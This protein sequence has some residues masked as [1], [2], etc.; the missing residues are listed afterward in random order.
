MIIL[1]SQD[2]VGQLISDTER[3]AA[4][5]RLDQ[6]RTKWSAETA[7]NLGTHENEWRQRDNSLEQER[8]AKLQAAQARREAEER[9]AETLKQQ[10]VALQEGIQAGTTT[11]NLARANLQAQAAAA[12]TDAAQPGLAGQSQQP[13]QRALA[14]AQSDPGVYQPAPQAFSANSAAAQDAMVQPVDAAAAAAAFP[15]KTPAMES[16]L[17]AKA[18]EY[19]KNPQLLAKVWGAAGYDRHLWRTR[20]HQEAISREGLLFTPTLTHKATGRDW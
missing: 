12:A 8:V 17:K 10:R 13:P 18:Q 20:Y 9:N 15:A 4:R 16:S 7:A 2:L 19:E 3:P 5:V 1:S 6:L 14:A 11:L